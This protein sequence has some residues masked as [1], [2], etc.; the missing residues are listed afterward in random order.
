MAERAAQAAGAPDALNANAA[1]V[2]EAGVEALLNTTSGQDGSEDD[3]NEVIE[4][5]APDAANILNF[6]LTMYHA[7]GRMAYRARVK[8]AI[9]KMITYISSI[10]FTTG[11]T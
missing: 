8:D 1:R 6:M 3:F 9:A 11:C 2:A 4:Q 5:F 7:K 10:T